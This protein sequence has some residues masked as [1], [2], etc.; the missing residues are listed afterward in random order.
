MP[1]IR[2]AIASEYPIIR[3]AIATLLHR[4]QGFN[5]VAEVDLSNFIIA[6]DRQYDVFVI[7]L[8]SAGPVGLERLGAL[9][10]VTHPATVVV[11]SSS[12]DVSLVRSLFGMGI[13]AYVL[14]SSSISELFE[15]IRG[16]H[17]GRRYVDPRLG[18]SMPNLLARH[19]KP[20]GK[21]HASL[22]GRESEVVR[23]V[24]RG[25][26]SK[27]T[28]RKLG[29]SQKT[30]QT[31]RARIYEKLSLHTRTEVVQYAIGHGMLQWEETA[32]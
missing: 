13:E 3:T 10:G 4:A 6:P 2:L 9:I 1:E 14:K 16:V 32:S 26:T 23:E 7:E 12:R 31:Y 18:D 20:N 8:T 11:L 30:V 5:V 28:A 17:R 19:R 15:A 29:V 22:S 27:A 24:A 21:R 25:L